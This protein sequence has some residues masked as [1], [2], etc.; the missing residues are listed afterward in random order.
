VS[1]ALVGIT[2]PTHTENLGRATGYVGVR[3]EELRVDTVGDH[4][5]SFGPHSK[6]SAD[7]PD[8]GF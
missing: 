6:V 2:G 3:M 7:R 5:D 4:P 1:D 8:T